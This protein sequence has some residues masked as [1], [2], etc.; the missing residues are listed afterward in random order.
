MNAT[1]SHGC[2]M[3]GSEQ[4]L[5]I[6]VCVNSILAIGKMDAIGEF[7]GRQRKRVFIE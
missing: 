2:I 1:K 6:P 7:G 4:T 3:R 5:K